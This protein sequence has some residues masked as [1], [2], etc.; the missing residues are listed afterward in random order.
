[1]IRLAKYIKPYLWGLLLTILALYGQALGNLNLP[2]YM[3]EMV[4]VGIQQNGIDRPAPEA[5]SR[6][7]MEIILILAGE[8]PG[9][10]IRAAY[11]PVTA[12]DRASG[13]QTYGARYPGGGDSFY[14]REKLPKKE[15]EALDEAFGYAASVW[16]YAA[17][18]G[19]AQENLRLE[20]PLPEA[21]LAGARSQAADSPSLWKQNGIRV[22]Q[23]LYAELGLDLTR[24]Q[25]ARIIRI[26]LIMLA[27]ALACG[28]A[29]VLIGFLSSRI[30]AAVARDLRHD[31][32]SK[33]ESFSGLEFDS[34]STASLITRCT[35]DITQIQMLLGMG[36][37]MIFFAPIMGIG[38]IIMAL[39]KSV[40]MSWI[41]ALSVV[42]LMG[43]V[44]SVMSVVTPR[45][46]IIQQLVDK[47]NLTA[48]E[49][50]SGLM[51]I[52]AFGAQEYERVRFDGVNRELTGINLLV[53][54]IMVSMWPAMTLIMNGVTLLIIWVGA[55]YIA[56]SELQVGDMMAFMQ[57]AMHVI[58]SFLFMSMMF[59]T[60]PRTA[61]SAGRIADVLETGVSIQD[62]PQPREFS[63]A[64]KGRI[65]FRDV[66]FRYPGANQDALS[67]LNF[68][69]PE[70]K[71]TA[72]IGP[73]GSGK[74]TIAGLIL[75]FYETSRGSITLNG[76]DLRDLSQKN[77]RSRIG[78]VPQKSVL[79][80]GPVSFNL[81]YGNKDASPEEL[82]EAAAISQALD[83]IREMDGG[84]EAAL[85]QGGANISGG[86]KQ[87]L[88][89]ARAL[90]K[91]PEIL[92]FDDSFSALD[93]KTD[94]LL[95]RA[96]DEKRAGITRIVITQRVGTIMNAEQIIVLDEGRIAGMGRHRELLRNCPEYLEIASS[97]L[98]GEELRKELA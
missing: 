96:L 9:A 24:I 80:S 82:E 43:L 85:A 29:A 26:G 38:S 1:M 84:F 28:A 8:E 78:Y 7:G 49:N 12:A 64:L 48:R 89:V 69:V 44:L 5:L 10:R 22:T 23:F 76:I 30:A 81:R 70:G 63:G 46:K 66:S 97:Q 62:P 41:L 55:R 92:I 53:N 40:S 90:V 11:T 88:S 39:Q 59:I 67:G 3:S 56:V 15:A 36:I 47:L 61:V 74:S 33:V 17:Q 94:T 45:F 58:F 35:N 16:I 86:Q 57:Y 93:F 73:T 72:I 71:T 34:F 87:R 75:R 83:F 52:R 54:R 14:V 21:A 19:A 65:E 42:I 13:G 95:R 32:F 25:T 20:L 79:L 68:T 2:Y 18:S 91:N 27:I 6:S 37:R 77:L 4:N 60:I 31:V 51:V 50:L 98:S